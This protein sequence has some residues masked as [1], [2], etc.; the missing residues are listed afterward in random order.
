MSK[1]VDL[2]MESHRS[3]LAHEVLQFASDEQIHIVNYLPHLTHLLQSLDVGIFRPLT[4]KWREELDQFQVDGPGEKPTRYNFMTMLSR[5]YTAALDSR[6]MVRNVFRKTDIDVAPY[7]ETGSKDPSITQ[8]R[9]VEPCDILGENCNMSHRSN[10][11]E[12]ENV[13]PQSRSSAV[14]QILII[15]T[16]NKSS[17]ETTKEKSNKSK[18]Q[19][20]KKKN[21]KNIKV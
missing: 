15:P 18:K 13:E 19:I 2:F 21:V 10:E 5:A 7:L 8:E 16:M 12:K 6:A 9:T 17:K 14:C 3:H 4:Q 20:T 1:P 11:G